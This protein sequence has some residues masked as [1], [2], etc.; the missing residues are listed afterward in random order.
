MPHPSCVT[1]KLVPPG[2]LRLS[3]SLPA[4][5]RLECSR[6]ALLLP[7]SSI[8]QSAQLRKEKEALLDHTEAL[9][10]EV[11]SLQSRVR[12]GAT[13]VADAEAGSRREQALL[14]E[15]DRAVQAAAE[16]SA[17]AA[18]ACGRQQA[19]EAARQAAEQQAAGAAELEA[20]Q[21]ELLATITRQSAELREAVQAAKAAE[22]GREGLEVQVR[23][24]ERRWKRAETLLGRYRAAETRLLGPAGVTMGVE[25][26][27]RPSLVGTRLVERG[28]GGGGES[29][30]ESESKAEEEEAAEAEPLGLETLERRLRHRLEGQ[31][32]A[33]VAAQTREE[34]LQR[35]ASLDAAEAKAAA[36]AERL[37][38]AEAALLAARRQLSD[39]AWAEGVAAVASGSAEPHDAVRPWKRAQ[40]KLHT[41]SADAGSCRDGDGDDGGAEDG[42]AA[43]GAEA[44]MQRDAEAVGEGGWHDLP[45]L[46]TSAPLLTEAVARVWAELRAARRRAELAEGEVSDLRDEL[47]AAEQGGRRGEEAS[48]GERKRLRG[49]VRRLR[50]ERD[51]ARARLQRATESAELSARAAA[52]AQREAEALRGRLH[53]ETEAGGRQRRAEAETLRAEARRCAEAAARLR[54]DRDALRTRLAS[55]AQYAARAMDL[56]R[57]RDV[58]VAD[59]EARSGLRARIVSANHQ[60]AGVLPQTEEAPPGSFRGRQESLSGLAAASPTPSRRSRSGSWTAS[61]PRPRRSAPRRAASSAQLS[62]QGR[63]EAAARSSRTPPR[64]HTRQPSPAPGSPPPSPAVSAASPARRSSGRD[65]AAGAAWTP[66]R[67]ALQSAGEPPPA[68]SSRRR[69]RTPDPRLPEPGARLPPRR[70]AAP[71]SGGRSRGALSEWSAM[72]DSTQDLSGSLDR[73]SRPKSPMDTSL[74][75]VSASTGFAAASPQRRGGSAASLPASPQRRRSGSALAA[76]VTDAAIRWADEPRHGDARSRRG[77]AAGDAAVSIP[78]TVSLPP[79]SSPARPR[80]SDSTGRGATSHSRSSGSGLKGHSRASFAH[81][82]PTS[83]TSSAKQSAEVAWSC[84]GQRGSPRQPT[85]AHLRSPQPH[86]RSPARLAG[87]TEHLTRPPSAALTADT[88]SSGFRILATLGSRYGDPIPSP[89]AGSGGSPGFDVSAAIDSALHSPQRQF[90][91]YVLSAQPATPPSAPTDPLRR[92]ELGRRRRRVS[93]IPASQRSSPPPAR[94]RRPRSQSRSHSRS[95]SRSSAVPPAKLPSRASR[96]RNRPPGP[97][98][99]RAAARRRS[100]S[101][102]GAAAAAAAASRGPRRRVSRGGGSEP[103]AATAHRS[104]GRARS[105]TRE[106]SRPVARS[107]SSRRVGTA[108]PANAARRTKH[109]ASHDQQPRR[110]R[111]A[112]SAG[113]RKRVKAKPRSSQRTGREAAAS[114]LG[115]LGSDDVRVTAS[116]IADV[117]ADIDAD[118]ASRARLRSRRVPDPASVRPRLTPT[119]SAVAPPKAG[120]PTSL[121]TVAFSVSSASSEAPDATASPARGEPSHPPPL[122]RP[123]PTSPRAS[124]GS[125]WSSTG[126]QLGRF[127]SAGKSLAA[128]SPSSSLRA[129]ASV[130]E[131]RR[132][133][134]ELSLLEQR[135]RHRS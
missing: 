60:R 103:G 130:A 115:S 74:A 75:A 79:S 23:R 76:P 95:R 82:P 62:P 91:D 53:R 66:G 114:P 49:A 31:V 12:R 34:R 27:G 78:R 69:A 25:A 94:Q 58:V 36:L 106:S 20:V 88:A 61:P 57:E 119:A 126:G 39:I 59:L 46:A 32:R 42:G 101:G 9:E 45:A 125:S 127:V 29:A 18:E 35:R 104:P 13:A 92:A 113:T 43:G 102:P 15:R 44:R 123:E 112:A 77:T 54:G 118:T 134:G 68:G 65:P 108:S 1:R 17:R 86:D 100:V 5:L 56:V 67:T 120:S 7:Q 11:R 52:G 131:L 3:S 24:E 116:G 90:D 8:E 19:A 55:Q 85:G 107:A 72:L 87:S 89:P 93:S 111:P 80:R 2:V 124:P 117:A 22:Q 38:G 48:A 96:S 41:A 109:T 6:P 33:E 132:M 129:S 26:E 50:A 64:R 21:A 135:L 10:E 71:R 70:S 81:P 37:S 83:T 99:G 121:D 105:A 128:A 14:A 97:Q 63:L 16:A 133:Q 110:P 40:R 122:R 84:L 51:D 30:A 73:S 47:L 28:G 98:A 4:Q